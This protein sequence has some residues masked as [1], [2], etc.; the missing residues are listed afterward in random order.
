M[1]FLFV[2]ILPI[3]FSIA[4]DLLASD[5]S[6]M[7]YGTVSDTSAV[8]EHTKVYHIFDVECES[9]CDQLDSCTGYAA[10]V[11]DSAL[12]VRSPRGCWLFG[13]VNEGDFR[14]SPVLDGIFTTEFYTEDQNTE[15][16]EG[17]SPQCIQKTTAVNGDLSATNANRQRTIRY[18]NDKFSFIHS[19]WYR[20]G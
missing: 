20:S 9:L 14:T 6:E 12:G 4:N 15:S 18:R 2:V 8:L 5:G 11:Y 7:C 1:I 13:L 19:I 17:N 16:A 10:N 3:T